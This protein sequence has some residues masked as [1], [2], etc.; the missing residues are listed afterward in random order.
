MF[1]RRDFIKAGAASAAAL[2]ALCMECAW[3][4]DPDVI[5]DPG[6]TYTSLTEQDRSLLAVLTPMILAE[7]LPSDEDEAKLAIKVITPDFTL[8]YHIT[9]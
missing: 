6:H 7:A 1:S 3:A 4:T 2:A 9:N 5:D 8:P